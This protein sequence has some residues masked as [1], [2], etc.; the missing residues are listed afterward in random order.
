[1]NKQDEREVTGNKLNNMHEEKKTRLKLSDV[2]L[3]KQLSRIN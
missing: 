2:F 3:L 1:M